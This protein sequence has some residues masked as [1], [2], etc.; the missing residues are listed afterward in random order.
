MPTKEQAQE[1]RYAIHQRN[2]ILENRAI[3]PMDKSSIVRGPSNVA[4]EKVRLRTEL[5]TVD[6]VVEVE[7][8]KTRLQ[9]LDAARLTERDGDAKALR[10]AEMNRRNKIENLRNASEKKPV[11]ANLKAGDPGYDPFS[12]RWIRSTN[13]FLAKSSTGGQK[14]DDETAAVAD[15]STGA[16]TEAASGASKSIDTSAPSAQ[17]K[18]ASGSCKSVDTSAPSAPSISLDA[19][20]KFGGPKGVKT[21]FIARKQRIEANLGRKVPEDDGRKHD[22]ALTVAEY[23]KRRGLL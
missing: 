18:A 12:R 23:M 13:Y 19:L 21:G 3:V 15:S 10:L 11:N 9:E 14:D 5:E 6:D 17:A 20:Q 22:R 2:F 4:A 8:I 1:K 16:G 7:R